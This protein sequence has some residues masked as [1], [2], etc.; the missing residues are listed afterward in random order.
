MLRGVSSIVGTP[1]KHLTVLIRYE[2][3]FICKC[4]CFPKIVVNRQILQ[5]KCNT[6]SSM[7][8]FQLDFRRSSSMMDS[9]SMQAVPY[10]TIADW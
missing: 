2:D 4:H 8:S 6:G 1:E 3:F 5:A 9:S 7:S 10:S